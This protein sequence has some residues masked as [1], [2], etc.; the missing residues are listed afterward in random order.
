MATLGEPLEFLMFYAFRARDPETEAQIALL[1]RSIRASYP[2]AAVVLQTNATGADAAI[3]GVAV[4]VRAVHAEHIMVE[5]LRGY[6][7]R[8]KAAAP[9]SVLVFMDTDMLV[10]R[11]FDELMRPGADL[12]VTV[13]RDPTWPINAGLVV[14]RTDKRAEVEDFFDRLVECCEGLPEEEKRW[15]GD[16]MA[17]ARL[18]RPEPGR[19]RDAYEGTRD[20]LAVRF[21]PSRLFNQTP[22]PWMLRLGI[23]RGAARILHFKGGRKGRMAAYARLY[24]SGAFRAYVRRRYGA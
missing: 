9:N 16:Q 8:L 19:F 6:R 22:R 2:E 18:L 1:A 10:L 4:E 11:R 5:R 14:A 15:Y 7:D 12:A 13:R 17:L 20:G 3:P 23:Y 21:V 24:L